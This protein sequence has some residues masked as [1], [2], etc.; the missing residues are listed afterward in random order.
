MC[1]AASIF[2]HQ[3]SFLLDDVPITSQYRLTPANVLLL[4]FLSG[5]LVC[6]L[7]GQALPR[8]AAHHATSIFSADR[9]F[10]SRCV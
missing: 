8:P 7:H 3:S 10:R 1:L 6:C 9:W 5:A 2:Q 4:V